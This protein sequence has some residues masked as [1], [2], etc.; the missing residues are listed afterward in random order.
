MKDQANFLAKLIFLLDP[1]WI[2]R[3]VLLIYLFRD[4]WGFN[5]LDWKVNFFQ[6][7][8]GFIR[9]WPVH[10][11]RK[12][13]GV[14]CF[15]FFYIFI[16]HICSSLNKKAG[17][18]WYNYPLGDGWSIAD[19]RW[20]AKRGAMGP[21]WCKNDGIGYGSWWET[22]PRRV[23]GAIDWKLIYFTTRL[24]VKMDFGQSA[25]PGVTP[26]AA[27][28]VAAQKTEDLPISA[29]WAAMGA[30]DAEYAREMSEVWDKHR[31]RKARM[32]WKKRHT[33]DMWKERKK[34]AQRFKGNYSSALHYFYIICVILRKGTFLHL[35]VSCHGARINQ[36][37]VMTDV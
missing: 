30:S 6:S 21:E 27:A 33:L 9:Y 13:C 4:E 37:S 14:F 2:R 22:Y 25:E 19:R 35:M 11:R 26:I 3:V 15:C 28:C 7:S 34:S 24:R 1:Y 31:K 10:C 32:K 16:P 29:L 17:I 5:E 23:K 36:I 18:H 20:E 12:W 8:H